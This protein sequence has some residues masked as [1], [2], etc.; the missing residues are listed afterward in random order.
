MY[1]RSQYMS[2]K[3]TEALIEM[4]GVHKDIHGRNINAKTEVAGHLAGD[5][6]LKVFPDGSCERCY[7]YHP[8]FP[9][10]LKH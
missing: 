10:E 9:K 1:D 4:F 6:M 3:S 8:D 5:Y 7:P 2:Q